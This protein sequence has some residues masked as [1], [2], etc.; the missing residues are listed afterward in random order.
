MVL[1]SNYS[2]DNNQVRGNKIKTANF[3]SEFEKYFINYHTFF[4]RK[5]YTRMKGM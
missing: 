2:S 1:E 4:P 3:A 5:I